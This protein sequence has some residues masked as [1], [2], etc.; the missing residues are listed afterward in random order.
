M[1][2]WARVRPVIRICRVWCRTLTEGCWCT[3]TSGVGR[4]VGQRVVEVGDPIIAGVVRATLARR[5]VDQIRSYVVANAWLT[6][7][8]LDKKSIFE[9]RTGSDQ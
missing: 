8:V 2:L 3:A 5:A 4:K 6:V 9:E 1:I 7:C